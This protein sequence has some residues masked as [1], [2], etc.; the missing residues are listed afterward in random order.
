VRI[1]V[2]WRQIHLDQP[3]RLSSGVVISS[4]NRE[5]EITKHLQLNPRGESVPDTGYQQ[6]TKNHQQH[7]ATNVE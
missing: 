3:A 7:T 2:S 6:Q 1:E 4:S 5:L